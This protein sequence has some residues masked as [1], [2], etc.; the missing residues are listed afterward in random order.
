MLPK[1]RER[2]ISLSSSTLLVKATRRE[3]QIII[4]S[5]WRRLLCKMS[6]LSEDAKD[7]GLILD[8][9]SFLVQQV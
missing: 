1:R 7:Q 9:A 8:E 3:I 6:G 5:A 2:S 4:R